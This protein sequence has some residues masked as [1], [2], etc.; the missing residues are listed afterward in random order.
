ME[1]G[2]TV[3][4]R[5]ALES[6]AGSGGMGHVYRAR[7]L[8]TGETV[9]LKVL[10]E[11]VP[12]A[13]ERFRRE[14]TLLASLAH[15]NVVAHVA[16]GETREGPYL[17]MEWLQGRDLAAELRSRGRLTVDETLLVAR[18]LASGL[19]HAHAM[20][21]VHRDVKPSNVFFVEG[22]LARAKVIDFGLARMGGARSE[23]THTGVI[24]GT[25]GYMAP[26][27][28]RGRETLE[29]RADVFSL[30]CV[31]FKC[32]TGKG[33]FQA[34]DVI[35]TLA[36]VLF[37]AAPRVSET[38]AGAQPALDALLDE[39]LAKEPEHRPSDGAE[40]A[41]R[42]EYLASRTPS[43]LAPPPALGRG[44][45]KIISVVLAS[46]GG[47][48][49]ALDPEETLLRAPHD[50]LDASSARAAMQPFG[51][52]L[53]MLPDGSFV[54]AFS[55]DAAASDQ[56]TRAAHC[57]LAL[58]RLLPLARVA[59]ATGR[60]EVGHR[61]VGEAIDRATTL[62][63]EMPSSAR[64]AIDDVTAGLLDARFEVARADG[65][66]ALR[67][68]LAAPLAARTLLGKVSPCV[69]RERELG[70]LLGVLDSCIE[71]SEA[72]AVVVTAPAG[73]GKSRL[74]YELLRAV[75]GSDRDVEVWIARGDSMSAGSAFGLIGPAIRRAVGI[76]EG[77]AMGLK[78]QRL[79]ARV[80]EA[81][82]RGALG[83][84]EAARVTEFL[85][86]LVSVPFDEEDR[87]QLRSARRDPVVMAD[88]TRRAFTD[89][90][91]AECAARPL[92][93]VLEDV[94]WGDAPSV[95]YV[96][97]ALRA[98]RSSPLFVLALARPEVESVFPGLFAERG[99][100]NVRLPGL[101]R[102]AGERLVRAVL[103]A[104]VSPVV[105]ARIVDQAAGNAF[106][107]EELVRAVADGKGDE[108]PG[109][110]LAMAQGRLDALQSELRRVLRAA[111]V[112][113]NVFWS[114]A[115]RALLGEQ[116]SE[117][118]ARELAELSD[119]ELVEARAE[120]RFP[121]Q[122]ELVFRHAIM[123]DAAY[124]MLTEDDRRV[125]HALAGDWLER[126]GDRDALVLASHFERGG[127]P[128]RAWPHYARAAA[129]ALEAGD[130]RGAI[131]RADSAIACGISGVELGR[132]KI[133]CA[134]AHRWLAES[135]NAID[136]AARAMELLPAGSDD[137]FRAS[138]E[139][140]F[141]IARRGDFPE[142]I[143]TASLLRPYLKGKVSTALAIASARVVTALL[144]AGEVAVADGILATVSAAE[145]PMRD[146]VVR[147]EVARARGLRALHLGDPV[148]HVRHYV[149]ALACFDEAG[150]V[151]SA[152]VARANAGYAR[153]GLGLVAEALEDLS[154]ALVAAERLELPYVAAAIRHNYA[155]ALMLLGRFA[156][157][158]EI[159]EG[160]IAFGRARAD[161]QLLGASLM[162]L[163]MVYIARGEHVEAERVSREAL[164]ALE[165]MPPLLVQGRAILADALHHQ[166]RVAEARE[167]AAEGLEG[168]GQL[169]GIEE[170][171]SRL[172]AVATRCLRDSGDAD[173][174]RALIRA[175]MARLEA[176]AAHIQDETV[177]AR[178]LAL[179]DNARCVTLARELA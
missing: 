22:D 178:F 14:A 173:G 116:G 179:E 36:K 102:R 80:A 4:G 6:L 156:E 103:G 76:L 38:V 20:G 141:G 107:L 2:S 69:G 57:A 122:R 90:L 160:V 158:T 73:T 33:P 66:Y 29:P 26:E 151:R 50:P 1:P 34:A 149:E 65:A 21:L 117:S 111:S 137:Y 147:A 133:V 72:R 170:G 99:A 81:T 168:L 15:P 177:R 89:F 131:A 25:P 161:M 115:V 44:E 52:E 167:V 83:E 63:H 13:L 114:D 174:A 120:A 88:Q 162:Y 19:G 85:G 60:A 67:R 166:G 17:A 165:G 11:G 24:V 86:E 93:L 39:L 49:T 126:S 143:L 32:L 176:R 71:E 56:A 101:S 171:E 55:G 78:R 79:R 148:E 41:R 92:V 128:E 169:G 172:Y 136:A 164:G 40:V 74:R 94:H 35:G 113:G 8:S 96:D 106:Y 129:A 16:H 5:F 150:D 62:L 135:Q 27:Q 152:C 124:E 43:S 154:T 108:L 155:F 48:P 100:T 163:G 105:V 51:G 28:A 84:V 123:R 132:L 119:R 70:N 42:I 77:E 3:D 109:T 68:P 95:A 37:E 146:P 118:L 23:A 110:V 87:V 145:G 46:G 138:A 121:G 139:V 61:L 112:F 157:A 82:R 91:A 98:L 153:L 75:E 140:V 30:G 142:V 12:G 58:Q 127:V 104:D 10:R 159:L 53:A 134:E 64:V 9:A 45:R 130:F 31:I 54:V 59:L 97:Y 125:G 47:R 7:D 18:Q 175:G 144:R